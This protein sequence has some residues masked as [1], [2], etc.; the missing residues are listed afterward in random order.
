LLLFA[1]LGL[2]W[3]AAAIWPMDKTGLS[4]QLMGQS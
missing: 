3:C 4:A 1:A 2:A